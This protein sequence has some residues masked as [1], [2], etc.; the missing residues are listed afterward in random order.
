MS[1]PD[2]EIR[3]ARTE[4]DVRRCFAAFHELRPHVK[5]ANEFVE[6]WRAQAVEGYEIAYVA[7]GNEVPAAAGYRV[8]HT[9]AWGKVLYIDDLVAVQAS[10]RTGLGSLLLRYLQEEA[11]RRA[12][13]AVHLDTGY[14]RHLA[15]RAYLRNGFQFDC[16]H[17]A[18]PSDAGTKD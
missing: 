10:Q 8:M 18:W 6:R 4:D 7:R 13:D 12:C 3:V 1:T 17:M 15:H 5:S 11:R 16:H 14:H 9:M 2:R